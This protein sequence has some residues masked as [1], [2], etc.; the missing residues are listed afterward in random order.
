M[1]HAWLTAPPRRTAQR[2]QANTNP[3]ARSKTARLYVLHAL[4]PPLP[5]LTAGSC[6]AQSGT[7][8]GAPAAAPRQRLLSWRP[9]R[10][11]AAS[12]ASRRTS[13]RCSPRAPGCRSARTPSTP[14]GSWH[15]PA[16]GVTGPSLQ[17]R[18]SVHFSAL[19]C[20]GSPGL[21][22]ANACAM[23]WRNLLPL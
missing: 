19:T 12:R 14:P 11:A 16:H 20:Y 5:S 4:R 17:Q 3:Q 1:E 18:I 22:A 23:H 10:P 13:R 9:R 15:P 7:S 8:S 21:W 6:S 2:M